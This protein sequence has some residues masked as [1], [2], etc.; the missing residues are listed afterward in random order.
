MGGVWRL[1]AHRWRAYLDAIV[2]GEDPDLDEYG[3]RLGGIRTVTDWS[4]QE[5]ESELQALAEDDA[6]HG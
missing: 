6:R 3:V 5:A 1:T 2:A 4:A